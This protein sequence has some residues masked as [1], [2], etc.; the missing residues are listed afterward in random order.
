MPLLDLEPPPEVTGAVVAAAAV[1]MTTPLWP[2]DVVAVV[3]QSRLLNVLPG[4][5]EQQVSGKTSSTSA[6][7]VSILEA[8]SP[9]PCLNAV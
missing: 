3:P 1:D 9:P 6:P 4:G 5:G 2:C 7:S 8:T